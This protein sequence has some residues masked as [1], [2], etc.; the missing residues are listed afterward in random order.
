MYTNYLVKHQYG[1][2]QGIK[3]LSQAVDKIR[4]F[5][6]QLT[7]VQADVCQLSLC[8]RVFNT[9]L[10]ILDIDITS[11]AGTPVS[12]KLRAYYIENY[13]LIFLCVCVW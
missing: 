4:L 10:K 2:I 3:I 1:F 11:I 7:A 12:L 9:A 13:L 6:S 5:D 8:A